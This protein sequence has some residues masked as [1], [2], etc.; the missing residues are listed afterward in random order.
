MHDGVYIG[1]KFP[2]Q[3]TKILILGESHH[4]SEEV[5]GKPAPYTTEDIINEYLS[6]KKHEIKMS[7]SL[8]FFTKI[9]HS[10]DSSLNQNQTIE[11][12]ESVAFGNYIDVSCGIKDGFAQQYLDDDN[13]NRLNR[14]LFKFVN[15][16][17][18]DVVICFSKLAFVSLPNTSMTED[19]YEIRILKYPANGDN[20]LD[21]ELRIYGIP[22]PSGYGFK[23]K[24]YNI[25]LKGIYEK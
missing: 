19:N 25:A 6:A 2:E 8:F 20:A 11:F 3:K 4:G 13:R 14:D 24:S 15:E 12:W 9:A 23:P 16:Y 22:H 18:I 1:K 10:F 17:G 5:K 7:R 21:K